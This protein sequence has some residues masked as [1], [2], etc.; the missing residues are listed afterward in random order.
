MPTR[1]V[2]GSISRPTLIWIVVAA[3][4]ITSGIGVYFAVRKGSNGAAPAGAPINLDAP[5][6]PDVTDGL[7]QSYDGRAQFSDKNDP[8]RLAGEML[9]KRLDPLPRG[10]YAL[11][12]PQMWVFMKDGRTLHMQATKGNVKFFQGTKDRP[13]SGRFEGGVVA[14]M[15]AAGVATVASRPDPKVIAPEA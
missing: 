8:N 2:R 5:P 6:A 1:P 13:E 12:Q 9:Y 3:F 4:L 7:P 10:R 15:Y 14:R 11:E